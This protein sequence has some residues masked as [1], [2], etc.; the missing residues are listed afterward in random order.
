[1][2]IKSDEP[3]IRICLGRSEA[4]IIKARR[5]DE[6]HQFIK[7]INTKRRANKYS[8]S[9]KFIQICMNFQDFLG[10]KFSKY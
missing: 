2:K 6:A 9:S 3:H 1:M 10:R 7:N 5:L 8:K 4:D